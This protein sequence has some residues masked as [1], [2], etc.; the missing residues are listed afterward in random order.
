MEANPLPQRG[1]AEE[2]THRLIE[3]T[4]RGPEKPGLY[5]RL[6][7]VASSTGSTQRAVNAAR[8]L[9]RVRPGPA[10]EWLAA[11]ADGAIPDAGRRA[12]RLARSDDATLRA[13]AH[14]HGAQLE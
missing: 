3:A 1:G 6:I 2:A 8:M 10:C 7:H 5:R 12:T 14:V 9:L 11:V 4:A 13:Q